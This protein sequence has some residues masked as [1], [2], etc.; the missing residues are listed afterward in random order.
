[1]DLKH[2]LTKNIIK[3]KKLKFKIRC[4]FHML[5]KLLSKQKKDHVKS[6]FG[7]GEIGEIKIILL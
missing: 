1:V 6:S 4:K 3:Q 7:Y 5:M 2:I